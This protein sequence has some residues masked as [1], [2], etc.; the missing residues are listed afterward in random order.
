[1]RTEKLTGM[2]GVC[3][4]P[5][6]AG[7]RVRVFEMPL[8]TCTQ[9]LQ[10]S[11]QQ[12]SSHPLLLSWAELAPVSWCCI[13]DCAQCDSLIV[14]GMSAIAQAPR[15]GAIANA[16]VR[17]SNSNLCIRLSMCLVRVFLY[18]IFNQVAAGCSPKSDKVQFK[19]S[20]LSRGSEF[21]RSRLWLNC[22]CKL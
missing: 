13:S 20:Q 12:P 21:E 11:S 8:V 1:M 17:S 7:V 6:T 14:T 18:R 10:L 16:R 3:G 19:S 4:G 15:S 22:G 9:L 5:V 2:A